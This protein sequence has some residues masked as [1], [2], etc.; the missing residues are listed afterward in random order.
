MLKIN[1][2]PQRADRNPLA[3]SL[4]GSVLTVDGTDYDL[5]LIPDGATVEHEVIRD[6]SRSGDDYE[7]TLML[8]LGANAPQE[9]RFPAP[10][11]VTMDGPISL[12]AY[13]D[14]EV[15]T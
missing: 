12:P 13:D 4:A 14:E 3:A 7:L 10:V 5:A 2:C 1:L 15:T 11:V 8:P 6:C 9:S